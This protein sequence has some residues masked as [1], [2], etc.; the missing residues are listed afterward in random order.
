MMLRYVLP[1]HCIA[2]FLAAVIY[3]SLLGVVAF[4]S[5]SGTRQV[6]TVGCEQ[7]QQPLYSIDKPS[8][9]WG[10]G[11]NHEVEYVLVNEK[12]GADPRE[13]QIPDRRTILFRVGSMAFTGLSVSAVF[14]SPASALKEKNESLCGTG[15]FEHIYEYKCTAIGDIQD[16][17]VSK[18]MSQE[19][20]GVTDSLMGKLGF[21]TGDVVESID[22]D[23]K[24][25]ANIKSGKGTTVASNRD[26]KN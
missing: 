19:E 11:S 5:Y 10:H 8:L 7:T 20:T 4:V 17:G 14:P 23:K 13:S 12:F 2:T 18:A 26:G 3:D 15:F 24:T 1:V 6:Q 25:K 21:D 16:E 22:D 9:L